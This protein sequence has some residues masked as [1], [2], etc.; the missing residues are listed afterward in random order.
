MRVR[1]SCWGG[2]REMMTHVKCD[3]A[4]AKRRFRPNECYISM[5]PC[6]RWMQQDNTAAKN[7]I[8]LN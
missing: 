3:T 5:R 2:N 7:Y 6:V 1:G 4:N 8:I